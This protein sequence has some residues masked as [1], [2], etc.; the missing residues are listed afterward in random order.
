[1]EEILQNITNCEGQVFHTIKGKAFSYKVIGLTIQ[2]VGNKPYPISFTNI[3]NAWNVG[4]VPG[5]GAYP[6]NIVGPSYVWALLND[7]RINVW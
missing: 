6:P 1:M 3:A 4:Q 5:P 2:I 7:A